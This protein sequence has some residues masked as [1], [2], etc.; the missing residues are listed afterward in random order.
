M[1]ELQNL[2]MVLARLV[3]VQH[4]QDGVSAEAYVLKC[5][6]RLLQAAEGVFCSVVVLCEPRCSAVVP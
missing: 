3:D 2:P 4:V 1:L 5:L 6:H